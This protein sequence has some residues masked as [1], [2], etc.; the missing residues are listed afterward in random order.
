MQSVPLTA[1]K[2]PLSTQAHLCESMYSGLPSGHCSPTGME[3]LALLISTG[4]LRRG[5]QKLPCVALFLE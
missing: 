2:P 4:N 5:T 3:G 1:V